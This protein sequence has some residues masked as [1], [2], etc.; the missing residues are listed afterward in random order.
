MLRTR[1]ITALILVAT[2]LVALFVFPPWAWLAFCAVVVAGGVW[3][4]AGLARMAHGA[5]A[6]YAL[7]SGA[8]ALA[9]GA[10]LAGSP[11]SGRAVGVSGTAAGFWLLVAPWWLRGHWKL[12]RPLSAA[13]IGWLVLLPAAA[14]LVLLR[15]LSPWLLLAGMALVWVAD[16]AAYFTGRAFGRHK[17]APAISPGKTWEGAAGAGVA[18]LGYGFAVAGASAALGGRPRAAL[19]A[20]AALLL[21]LTAISVVGAEG[22]VAAVPAR[23]PE[24]HAKE[25][26]GGDRRVDGAEFSL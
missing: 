26:E 6:A 12:G 22:T 7:V 9:V 24:D 15:E 20:F 10:V 8:L 11:G 5:R 23:D 25:A 21:L 18:V 13:L 16:I 1:V 4:W 2:F 14:A 19:L 17:L 3:E